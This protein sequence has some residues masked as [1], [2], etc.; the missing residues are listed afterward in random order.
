LIIILGRGRGEKTDWCSGG[1]GQMKLNN[2]KYA[3][4]VTMP[5]KR[6]GSGRFY[7]NSRPLNMQT[8]QDS[9]PMPFIDDVISQLGKLAWFT[10]LDL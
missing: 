10:T 4:H 9:F 2:F 6:D 5:I 7:G 8:H 3:C 1:Y